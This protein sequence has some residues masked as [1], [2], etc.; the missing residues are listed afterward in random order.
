MV[1]LLVDRR[2][3]LQ[4]ELLK[5]VTIQYGYLYSSLAFVLDHLTWCYGPLEAGRK[6]SASSGCNRSLFTEWKWNKACEFPD[7]LLIRGSYHLN[8]FTLHD[9]GLVPKLNWQVCNSLNIVNTE[10]S[11]DN[12]AFLDYQKSVPP[13][14]KGIVHP[15]IVLNIYWSSSHPRFGWVC[16]FFAT[17]LEK[18]CITSL[19][20]QWILWSEW[21]PSE[22]ESKQLIKTS[23]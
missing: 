3:M 23:K 1:Q 19:T 8:V 7:F 21:V 10:Q 2:I 9:P 20:Q 22:W 12:Q 11:I 16:L 14:I 5:E 17:D 4:K 13:W 15:G 18:F 6:G